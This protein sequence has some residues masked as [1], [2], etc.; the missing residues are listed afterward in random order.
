MSNNFANLSTGTVASAP[1]PATTGTTIGLNSGEG[2]RMPTTPF[3]ATAH[4]ADEVP[5]FDNAEIIKVTAVNSNTLTVTRAQKSTSAK[6]IALGW[7]IS[8]SIYAEDMTPDLSGSSITELSDVYSSTSPTDG[9][10]LIYDTTN[11]WQ[12]ETLPGGGDLLAANNLSDISNASTA[13]TNLGLVIGTDVQ[14]VLAEGA[15]ANGDKTKLDGIETGAD[16]TDTANVTAAGALMDSEVTNLAQV[17]AFDSSDYATAAQGATADSALQDITGEPL[18]DLSNVTI[19]TPADNEVLAYNSG[20]TT[21]INQT[22]AEAGLSATGHSHTESDI[23]DLQSYLTGITGEPLSDLSD[24]TITTIASGEVLKWNGSA[25]INN[26]L[27]EA[28]IAATSHSHAT[29]DITSGTL[30]D[31]RVAESNVTQHQAALSITESQVS[32]L[33]HDATKI[34]GVAVDATDIGNGKYLAYNS[35]SGNLEYETL[36]GGGDMSTSTYDGAGISEQLVGLTASQTLTNKTLTSPVLN[37]GVSGTAVKD[38]DNMSSNSATHLA[39]QQ[40]I[41]A[42][43]DAEISSAKQALLPVGSIVVLGVSTN[44][45]TLYGFGT[46]TQIQGQ[47][48]AGVSNTDGDFDLDDTGG[49]KTVDISHTHDLSSNGYAK[50]LNAGTYIQ[51]REIAVTSWQAT[52]RGTATGSGSSASFTNAV[53]LDG[54]T[55]S[56]GSASV[57]K[58]PPYIAKYIWQRTA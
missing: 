38:E 42:Y 39:T 32:D 21:W 55:D 11:G 12:A 14:G 46:W 56:G 3:F 52:N 37:T 10:A 4:P 23:S 13:R 1:S 34:Q 9:Q 30:A 53:E 43:V 26:T 20:T 48:I 57:D 17:K 54:A 8:A 22:A 44:P 24:V 25:W 35:T 19:T 31:A 45:N 5:T 40:S 27:A 16:V 49:A 58:L 2:A 7:R 36:A 41:K 28:G 18:A 50:V 47:F 51:T 6:S 33:D 15:F 29:S